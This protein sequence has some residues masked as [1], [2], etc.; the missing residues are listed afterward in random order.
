MAP[1]GDLAVSAAFFDNTQRYTM[2]FQAL[3]WLETSFRYSGLNDFSPQFSTFYDRAFGVK[4]RL[5][6]ESDDWPAVVIGTNDLVGTGVYSGEY[7]AASKKIGPFDFTLGMGWG[8]LATAA[9][10]RNPLTLLSGSF[11]KREG[12]ETVGQGGNFSFGRY[13]RGP[14]AGIFGGVSWQTPIDRLSVVAEY[15]S[16]RYVLETLPGNFIPRHQLNFGLSYSPFDG[17]QIGAGWLYGRSIYANFTMSLDPTVDPYPRR[18]GPLLPSPSIRSPEE[19]QRALREVFGQPSANIRLNNDQKWVDALWAGAGLQAVD[20]TGQTIRV[21]L[22][23]REPGDCEKL[24]KEI[25]GR[26]SDI[27]DLSINDTPP[28]RVYATMTAQSTLPSTISGN[29]LPDNLV[30]ID[31][32]VPSRA[33]PVSAKVNIRRALQEQNITVLAL[34]LRSHDV[35]IDYQNTQYSTERDAIDRILRTLLT[36]APAELETFRLTSILHGVPQTQ[37]E[38]PRGT[39]ERNF[40]QLGTFELFRDGA[41]IQPAPMRDD[42]PRDNEQNFYPKFNWSLAPQFRQQLFDPVNPLGVQLL[43]TADITVELLPGLRFITQVEGNLYSNF[44]VTRASDSVLPHVRTD[45]VR[46]FSEGKSGIASLQ[47]E[48]NF[49]LNPNTHV[50]LRGGY[51]ESMFAGVG[52]EILWRRE[53]YRWALGADLY[54]VRQRDFNRLLSLQDYQQTTGHVSLYYE[55]PWYN[56]YFQFR[57]GRY[58]AGDWGTTVQI[59]RRFASGIEIGAFATKTNVSATQFGEGSFDKGIIIRI[60]LAH[61]LPVN[62]QQFFGMDLR[63]I[64]RDGGQT[65]LGDA[66]LYERMR[67][68]SEGELRRTAQ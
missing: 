16:D 60:P 42:A 37:I 1:D 45:F 66:Q 21:R 43:V 51:L 44:N 5:W 65:L 24:A 20:I 38:I 39:A 34:S 52:G 10:I 54:H 22:A 40:E 30:V 9:T 23:K 41:R 55:S 7:V 62:T 27:T 56:L 49:R 58:L 46:Y 57:V 67:R 48:H 26:I 6:E 61:L 32:T 47:V 4:V 64:Q 3:P 68:T 13:F 50:T 63:P 28:C 12:S 33:D 2:S 17:T 31:A 36:E 53:G 8:R 25:G 35:Q 19:Q 29:V 18:I 14:N 15:S 11:E 59:S